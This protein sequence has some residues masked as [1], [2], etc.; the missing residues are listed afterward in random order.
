M[1]WRACAYS[2]FLAKNQVYRDYSACYNKGVK[3]KHRR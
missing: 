3:S 2:D 1:Q